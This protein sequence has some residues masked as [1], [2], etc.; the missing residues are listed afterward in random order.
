MLCRIFSESAGAEASPIAEPG[1]AFGWGLA[2]STPDSLGPRDSLT[3]GVSPH[4][5]LLQSGYR[6]VCVH[7]RDLLWLINWCLKNSLSSYREV[8]SVHICTL[9]MGVYKHAKYVFIPIWCSDSPSLK[10]VSCRCTVR[11]LK[12]TLFNASD[13]VMC[14]PCPI[15]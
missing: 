7:F 14:N 3:V 6:N 8:H 10:V 4:F 5:T 11:W 15:L 9:C 13:A 2:R 12:K 1:R